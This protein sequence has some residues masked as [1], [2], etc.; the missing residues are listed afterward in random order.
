MALSDLFKKKTPPAPAA[1]Q[2]FIGPPSEIPLDQVLTLRQQGFTNNQILETLRRQGYPE[3]QIYSAF[4]Q[5]DVTRQI[6]PLAT[7]GEIAPQQSQVANEPAGPKHPDSEVLV[8]QIIDEK[9]RELQKDLA[10]MNEWKDTLGSRLDKLEQ[11]T[12][13]LQHSLLDVHRA[14]IDQVSKSE[15]TLLDVGTEI[16]AVEKVLKDV[17]PQL[18][19]NIQELSRVTKKK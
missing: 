3:A 5:A 18:T 9:W 19:A 2:P 1:E 16:K 15:K 17:V 12:A 6:E 7:P 13:D 8:E 11:S 10:K 14:L 4:A